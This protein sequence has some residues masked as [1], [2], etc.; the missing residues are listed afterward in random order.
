[1][2]KILIVIMALSALSCKKALKEDPKGQVVGTQ[3]LGTV[4]GLNA[5]L[6]GAYKPLS[7]TWVNGFTTAAAVAVCMGSDD[8]TTHPA[9]NKADL[10]E[11]DQYHVSNLNGRMLNIWN[12]CYK[13]IQGANNIINNYKTTSGD[14]ASISQIVG[15]AYYLRALDYYWLIRLWGKIPLITSEV[16]DPEVLKVS[17]SAPAEVYKLIESDLLNAE[18]MMANKK[19]DAGRASKGAASALLADVYLTEG[20]WPINDNAKYALA[21]AKAKE[22]ID[23]K[24]AYGFDLVSDLST[25]W[26]NTKTGAATSEEVFAIHNCGACNWF[27][28]NA[29][30][31]SSA[32]PGEENGWDDYFTEIRFFNDF[33]AGIR[34][35]VTFHTVIKKNDGTTIPWQSDAV[36]HPY[37]QKFRAP[38]EGSTDGSSGTVHMMRYAHV[39]LIYAEAA[40]RTGNVN[41]EAYNS[42]NAIRTR[43]GLAPLSGLSTTD[44]VN[45][46]INER[47]WEFAGEF[48]RW[49]D[50]TR[51]QMLPQIIA[52]RDPSENA[53]IGAP[54]Y[55][56]PIP[57]GDLQLD[58]NLGK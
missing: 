25:L 30:Y 15:E 46:V 14:A 53:P 17:T 27:N 21:A 34:K 4:S 26:Q 38:V 33:P 47:A 57:A 12:G 52:K 23:N 7:T 37:F 6:V 2:K 35:D 16:Y 56:L 9:S 10:R 55:Y 36:K 28:A 20:G 31:G 29:L 3:A 43:A 45:A 51:L 19:L 50:I 11:F 18:K 22:V 42:I 41:E 48:T 5:A 8:L 24:A 39:L 40:A 44:F 58:P 1:M 13:S 49:F 54:Q 32:M